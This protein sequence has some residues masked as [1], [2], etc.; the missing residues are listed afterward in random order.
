METSKLRSCCPGK[1]PH[2]YDEECD[3]LCIHTHLTLWL[4]GG[5]IPD[6]WFEWMENCD[7]QWL[8][9]VITGIGRSE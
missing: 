2:E 3:S 1:F 8:G 5:I 4:N 6:S 7:T 9:L